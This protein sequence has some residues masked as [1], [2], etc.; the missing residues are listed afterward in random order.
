MEVS[1]IPDDAAIDSLP[2]WDSLGHMRIAAEIERRLGRML[3]TE[4]IAGLLD[5]TSVAKI[6]GREG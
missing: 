2:A 4:E 1:Q 6:L 3:S 5:L